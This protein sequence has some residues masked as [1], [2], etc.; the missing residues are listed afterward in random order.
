MRKKLTVLV[1][2]VGGRSVGQQ[3]LQALFLCEGKYRIVATDAS[4]F[5]YGLYQVEHRYIVPPASSPGYMAALRRI[6]QRENVDVVLPGTQPE[7]QTLSDPKAAEALGCPVVVSPREVVEL[8]ANKQSLYRWLANN[9]FAVP[10][11]ASGTGWKD[12]AKECGFPLVGKPAKDSGGSKGV[13]ILKDEREVEDYLTQVPAEEAVLQEYVGTAE[14]EYTVGVMVSKEGEVFDSIVVRRKL[15]GFTLGVHRQIGGH[16]Y[17]LSTGYSQGFIIEHPE[18]QSVCETLALKIGIRG[19]SNMQLRLAG[20]RVVFF[21]VH[22]RFS[23]TT[24]IRAL[25]GFNEPD[26]LIRNFVLG[27]KCGRLEYRV[28]VA[29]I[30]AFSNM[31]VP[32][33]DMNAVPE[34]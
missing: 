16:N 33:S 29:A 26:V 23:G 6:V 12:L 1:T 14:A 10:R 27:E 3:V 20:G 19:P 11:S 22:T 8:C 17:A 13:A 2:G 9:G 32:I 31:I 21:E 15:T 4:R 30:R 25:V 28:D 18:I 7:V 5:S 34:A 24:A